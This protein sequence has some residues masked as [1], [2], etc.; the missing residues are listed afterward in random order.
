MTI[1]IKEFNTRDEAIAEK[2]R[3]SGKWRPLHT[4]FVN[5]KWKVTFVDGTDDPDKTPEAE[6]KRLEEKTKKSRLEEL[7]QKI[8]TSTIMPAE[9]VEYIKLRDI[10]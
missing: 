6:Q 1:E 2:K 10:G 3:R 5:N 4:D 9:L 7:R 8:S